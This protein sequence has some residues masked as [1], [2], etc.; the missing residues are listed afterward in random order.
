MQYVYALADGVAYRGDGS[1][2]TTHRGTVW[3]ADDPFVVERPDLFAA[4][5]PTIHNTT[6]ARQLE[7]TSRADGQARPRKRA[8]K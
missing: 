6:G 8:G 1:M 2:V 5:P 3:A 7:V 4:E